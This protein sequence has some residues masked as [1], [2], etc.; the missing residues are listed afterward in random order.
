VAI[1]EALPKSFRSVGIGLAYALGVATLGGSTQFVVAWLTRATHNPLA[2][3]W[4]L[5]GGAAII[6]VA[7]FALPETAPRV[8]RRARLGKLAAAA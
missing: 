3:A 1:T 4:Y 8:L 7:I 2:P 6:L 5:T